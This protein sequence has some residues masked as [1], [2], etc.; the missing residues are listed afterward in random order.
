MVM[1]IHSCKARNKL[2]NIG[3]KKQ[4]EMVQCKSTTGR[5][6]LQILSVIVLKRDSFT[7]SELASTSSSSSLPPPSSSASAL[8]SWSSSSSSSS[9]SMWNTASL[10]FCDKVA[11]KFEMVALQS[12]HEE[13]LG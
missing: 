4:K 5:D 3:N 13:I 9:S 2:K 10:S 8:V 1:I 6:Q 12:R 11:I 7:L